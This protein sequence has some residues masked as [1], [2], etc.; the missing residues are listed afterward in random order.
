VHMM[1]ALHRTAGTRHRASSQDSTGRN[2]PSFGTVLSISTDR[3]SLKVRIYTHTRRY[4]ATGCVTRVRDPLSLT[5]SGLRGSPEPRGGRFHRQ[6]AARE[7]YIIH[8]QPV[9][10]ERS[11]HEHMR[12]RVS[13]HSIHSCHRWTVLRVA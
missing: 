9:R 4:G 13:I 7:H 3:S 5:R 6:R 10:W 8:T 12:D 2:A 11:S 1:R